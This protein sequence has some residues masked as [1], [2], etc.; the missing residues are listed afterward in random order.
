MTKNTSKTLFLSL[1]PYTKVTFAYISFFFLYIYI[2]RI[3][4]HRQNI[5]NLTQ[6]SS[7]LPIQKVKLFHFFQF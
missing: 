5:K 7:H 1:Y 3:K 2:L 6:K 4:T